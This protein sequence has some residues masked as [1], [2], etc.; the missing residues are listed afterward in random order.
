M[1]R[2]TQAEALRKVAQ[3]FISGKRSNTNHGI[4][5]ELYEIELQGGLSAEDGLAARSRAISHVDHQSGYAYGFDYERWQAHQ[6]DEARALACLWMA[7]EA[8]EDGK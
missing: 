2:M 3:M 8:E 6:N 4:C 7:L 5:L 1:K